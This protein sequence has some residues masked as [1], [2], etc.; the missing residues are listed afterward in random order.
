M[1]IAISLKVNDGVVLAADSASTLVARETGVDPIITPTPTPAPGINIEAVQVAN[2]YNNANKVFNLLKGAPIG[3]ITWGSGAIGNASISTLAKD[4]RRRFAGGDPDH[5]EWALVE[6]EQGNKR[7]KSYTIEG[8]AQRVRE[9]MYDELYRPAFEEWPRKPTL[10]F[11]VAGYSAGETMAEEYQ[12]A[13]TP[14][15]ECEGPTLLRP[16]DASGLTWNGQVEAISRLVL[17][18]SSLLPI[19]LQQN[20]GVPQQQIGP[21]TEVLKQALTAPMV[22]PPMPIQDAIDLAQFL[23]E[24]T[25]Q[26]TRFIPGPQIVGG[27]I[28]IAA[29]TKHE[30]FKWV[31]R[32]HYYGSELNPE[33]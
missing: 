6:Y 18:F 28:E 12:I 15:G 17:G 2:V 30:G 20:L 19:V 21:A 22:V 11:I 23:V 25:I 8:V 9:F 27:P 10:G 16:K 5:R 33:G 24:L 32:K 26:F 4:L 3:L 31:K 7:L 14:T 29:I 1:T 13:M